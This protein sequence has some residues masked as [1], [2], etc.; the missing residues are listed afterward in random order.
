VAKLPAALAG[1]VG[2]RETGLLIVSVESGSP[3]DSAGIL[4]GDILVE[5]GGAPVT[6]TD[7]LQVH[8]GP[9]RIGQATAAAILRGGELKNM[10]VTVGE[11]S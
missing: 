6:D 1:L 3:A 7:S 10:S 2:G 5:F 9:S 4:I 11:R 8:L